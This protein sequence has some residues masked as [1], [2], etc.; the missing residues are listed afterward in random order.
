MIEIMAANEDCLPEAVLREV[1]M[2]KKIGYEIDSIC[3]TDVLDSK[4]YTIAMKGRYN[5]A[6]TK[7]IESNG[8]TSINTVILSRPELRSL[9]DLA[10]R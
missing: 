4:H 1:K 2:N 9:L 10:E 6:V 3:V 8:K 7:A 5:V